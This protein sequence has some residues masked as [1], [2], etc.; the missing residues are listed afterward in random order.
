[1]GIYIAQLV[2]C[3][4]RMHKALSSVP[5]MH[6]LVLWIGEQRGSEDQ[7]PFRYIANSGSLSYMKSCIS[8]VNCSCC[9]YNKTENINFV[10]FL[11]SASYFQRFITNPIRCTWRKLCSVI[12]KRKCHKI[13][14]QPMK[15]SY[16]G[17]S[18]RQCLC[19]LLIWTLKKHFCTISFI[20]KC[21]F[22]I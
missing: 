7:G 19:V 13:T 22:S 17:I 5:S 3:L 20:S 1:M 4:P 12:R 6:K 11:A 21:A 16:W 2:N 10:F 8:A 15:N 9:L 14:S 18:S